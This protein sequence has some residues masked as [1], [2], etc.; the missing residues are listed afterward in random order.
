MNPTDKPSG[1]NIRDFIESVGTKVK[2]CRI[3]LSNLDSAQVKKFVTDHK[4]VIIPWAIL[5]VLAVFKLSGR[6]KPPKDDKNPKEPLKTNPQ[7]KPALNSKKELEISIP[8]EEYKTL[9]EESKSMR[10][11]TSRIS[12]TGDVNTTRDSKRK[13][14]KRDKKAFLKDYYSPQSRYERALR[15]DPSKLRRERENFVTEDGSDDYST[16]LSESNRRKYFVSTSKQV[17]IESGYNTDNESAF[18][19][20]DNG[21][22]TPS[23]NTQELSQKD[24]VFFKILQNIAEVKD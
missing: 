15:N 16:T 8:I 13:K 7:T 22:S 4:W 6:K 10:E 9:Q 24:A 18:N 1:Q 20:Q 21:N 17:I 19:D 3:H 2:D 12:A 11:E 14:K 5:G 23:I